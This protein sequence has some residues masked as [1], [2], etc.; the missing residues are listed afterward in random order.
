MDMQKVRTIFL[1]LTLFLLIFICWIVANKQ[2]SPIQ[3]DTIQ[4]GHCNLKSAA[5]IPLNQVPSHPNITYTLKPE[6]NNRYFGSDIF[7]LTLYKT[8]GPALDIIIPLGQFLNATESNLQNVTVAKPTFVNLTAD[9][10]IQ[11]ILLTVYCI[12]VRGD[13]PQRIDNYTIVNTMAA[14]NLALILNYINDNSLYDF[15]Y[16]QL[17]VW[18]VTDGPDQIPSGYI[19]NNTEVAWANALLAAAGTPYVIPDVPVI[20]SFTIGLV[21]AGLGLFLLYHKRSIRRGDYGGKF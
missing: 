9:D 21:F 11:S 13:V 12:N 15:H 16:T 2:P 10:D 17:A 20:P 7:N 4:V 3:T 8:Q 14:G 5:S 1:L 19:Y 18:A 6:Y